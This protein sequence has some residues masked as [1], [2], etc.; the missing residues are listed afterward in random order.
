MSSLHDLPT[1]TLRRLAR[2]LA[3]GSGVTA[4]VIEGLGLDEERWAI[5]TALASVPNEAQAAVVEA[6]VRER[7]AASRRA[8]ELVWT[9]PEA[10]V[11]ESR[12]SVVVLRDLLGSARQR[13]LLA[14]Y[15]FDHGEQ[16]LRPLYDAMVAHGVA[17]DVFM[18]V[19]QLG[20]VDGAPVALS[21]D[22]VEAQAHAFLG[23]NWPWEDARPALWFDRRVLEGEV[24]ASVH[25]KCAV[26]DGTR[27]Y[28]TSANFTQ[29]GTERNVEVGVLLSDAVFAARLEA[30]F[31]NARRAGWFE[32]AV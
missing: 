1:E 2:A 14:G 17:V 15:S 20:R 27:A 24:F 18:N 11:A 32:R 6:I 3:S 8:P 28:V 22:E 29:R 30:Q 25:A 10:D 16:L 21:R 12:R 4:S 31:V 19:S 9:G 23:A 5:E 26:V 7:A 13:V